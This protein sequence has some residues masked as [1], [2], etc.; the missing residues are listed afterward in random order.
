MASVGPGLNITASRHFTSW[1]AEQRVSLAV[2]TYQANKLFL[3]GVKPDGRL[4]AFERTFPRCMGM[5]ATNEGQTLWLTSQHQIWRLENMLLPGQ[6]DKGFDRL[7]VPQA[8]FVTGDLDAHDIAIDADGRVIFVNTLFSC[9]ATNSDRVSFQ[10]LWKPPFISKLAAEDRCHM[11]GLA[12]QDGQ[13]KY[14]TACSRSDVADGWRDHR[15][16]GGCV[17]EVPSGN[18]VATGLSMPHSPRVYREKLWLLN[19]GRGE[20][21]WVE[22]DSGRFESVAFCPGYA[23]GL[24]FHGDWAVIGLSRPREQTFKGLPLDEQLSRRQSTAR[25]GLQIVDLRTGDAPHWVRFEDPVHELYDVALLPDARLPKALGFRS[26]EIRHTIWYDEDGRR[27]T[28]S[29]GTRT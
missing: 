10:P 28:W 17:L 27:G 12:L 2:T 5:C 15:E 14:V 24:A 8:G 29:A 26:D 9:L 11:N 1:L 20:F 6:D 22:A 19:S 3:L 4:S 25:C 18:V 16:D 13:A 21:G 7:Y 23:R